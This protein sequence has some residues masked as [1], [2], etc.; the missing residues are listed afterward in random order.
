MHLLPEDKVY[1]DPFYLDGSS[2]NHLKELGLNVI[3]SNTDFF[4]NQVDYDIII[5]NPPFSQKKAVL[6]KLIKDG[7]PF[8]MIMPVTLLIQK[9]FFN[10]REF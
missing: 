2:G 5:T 7:K 4:T 10:G 3:H 9:T 8:I 6:E 1:Y